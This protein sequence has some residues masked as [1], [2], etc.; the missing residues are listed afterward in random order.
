MRRL[1]RGKSHR[2][3]FCGHQRGAGESER[4]RL[5]VGCN[6]QAEDVRVFLVW[7][8]ALRAARCA[9]RE[10]LYPKIVPKKYRNKIS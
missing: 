3:P 6:W 1:G 9:H 8:D 5:R 10:T 4:E 7:H 2:G